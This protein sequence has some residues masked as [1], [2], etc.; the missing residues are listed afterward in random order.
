LCLVGATAGQNFSLLTATLCHL[1][2]LCCLTSLVLLL[3]G[4]PGSGKGTQCARIVR[5]YGFEHLSA[6]DLLRAEINSGSGNG[7]MIQKMIED[8][9]IVP[10]EV[11]VRL[12][13][14]AMEKSKSDKFL[15][16]G[17]PRSDEN[18]AV[19]ERVVIEVSVSQ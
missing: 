4:G 7:T 2:K 9:K 3:A 14:K 18:R 5:D 6:G 15:I 8:G 1:D 12:L 13:Q 11:T 16:D 10:S 17:F 19:F